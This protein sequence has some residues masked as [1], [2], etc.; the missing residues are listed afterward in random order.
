M[1]YK[2]IDVW[3]HQA[4]GAIRYRCFQVLPSGHFCVQSADFYRLPSD[5]KQESFLN[6]QFL[7]LLIE[8]P[9]DERT[10]TFETLEEAVSRHDE[11]FGNMPLDE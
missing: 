3:R 10:Q 1:L 8:Q 2:A 6:Y 4:G 7:E 5:E 9:P 11:E